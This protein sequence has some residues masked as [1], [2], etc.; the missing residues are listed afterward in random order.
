MWAASLVAATRRVVLAPALR[1][2]VVS[3]RASAAEQAPPHAE[4]V[5][6]LSDV[7]GERRSE[8]AA[9]AAAAMARVG[10][11]VDAV[12]ATGIAAASVASREQPAD[13]DTDARSGEQVRV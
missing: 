6:T 3:A 9:A 4:R 1:R 11:H 2:V 10:T 12:R 13:S 7:L 8:L 5:R